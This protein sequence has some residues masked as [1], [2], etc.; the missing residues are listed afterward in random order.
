VSA[1]PA[2]RAG[3]I[4]PEM[5]ISV[6]LIAFFCSICSLA[7]VPGNQVEM[8]IPG[9]PGILQLDLGPT[10]FQT[11]VRPDGKE[12]QLRALERP[13]HL[14]ITAFLQRVDFPASAEKCR[15]EWWPGT[16]KSMAMQRED[17]QE[18]LVKDGIA[19]VEYVVPEF[20][21]V[22]VRQKTIHAYL[23]TRDLC[24]EIHL[25]KPGFEP[26]DQKLFEEVLATAK[27]LPDQSPAGDHGQIAAAPPSDDALHYVREGSK[28]YLQQDY[29]AAAASY[30]K[31]LDL[32]KQKHTLSKDYFRVLV[33]NL[34]M[35]YGIS[36]KLQQAKTTFEYG[37]TQDPEY[38]MFYYNL[39]CVY[40]EMKSMQQ[41]I[42]ELRLAY[43]HKG[44]MIAG[45]TLPD[46]LKDD[47]FTYFVSDGG[48][49]KAVADMQK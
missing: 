19:R 43:K 17:L 23:G 42:E 40:G 7:Q 39:A 37:L 26:G 20:Q 4:T 28:Y 38:P 6:S 45:E 18:S 8:A 36:G 33:D 11:R 10:K 30:Q 22:K 48:F 1:W 14:G 16:K 27:L 24:V 32:E 13:D 3:K 47:S 41:S 29:S 21:G 31:A 15:D 25:S 49:V 35:S 5:R 2:L 12:V 44:N 46:P 34:G 9:V